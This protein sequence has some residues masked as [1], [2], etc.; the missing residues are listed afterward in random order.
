MLRRVDRTPVE[1][2]LA[3]H[4]TATADRMLAED[5]AVLGRFDS[6]RPQVEELVV[7]RAQRQAVGFDVWPAHVMPLDVRGFQACWGQPDSQVEPAHAA[8]VLIGSQ[9]TFAEPWIATAALCVGV[10]RR[11]RCRLAEIERSVKVQA[12]AG[13]NVGMQGQREV[14][15]QHARGHRLKQAGDVAQRVVDVGGEATLDMM[16]AQFGQAGRDG[17]WAFENFAGS[18]QL[19]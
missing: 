10:D 14:R 11:E 1:L 18:L 9:H 2:Q 17:G 5:N 4:A 7:K 3:R 12:E 16:G 13:R 19:P 15:I 6:K 8:P